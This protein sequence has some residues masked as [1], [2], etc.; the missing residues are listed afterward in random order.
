[1]LPRYCGVMGIQ[2]ISLRQKDNLYAYKEE[3]IYADGENGKF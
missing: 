2:P 1:M 3:I